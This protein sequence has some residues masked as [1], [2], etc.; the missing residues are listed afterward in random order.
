MLIASSFQEGDN[1][2]RQ[3][4]PSI[5]QAQAQKYSPGYK[6]P[7]FCRKA[8]SSRYLVLRD[9]ARVPAVPFLGRTSG[10][11]ST[12]AE[13]VTLDYATGENEGQGKSDTA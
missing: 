8:V 13:E 6:R 5:W 1:L 12:L 10:P 3:N 7:G 4:E 11:A 9:Y 2:I